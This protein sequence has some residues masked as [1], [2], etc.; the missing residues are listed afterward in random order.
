MLIQVRNRVEVPET[1]RVAKVQSL[2]N[3]GSEKGKEFDLDAD[4]PVDSEGWNIGVVVG[5]SGSGKSSIGRELGAAG[6]ELWHGKPWGPGAI[7]DE[8]G[9]DDFDGATGSLAQVGLGTVPSWLR[10]FGVLSE[11]EKF[12]AEL[13]RVLVERPTRVVIDEF[14]SVVDRQ[15]AQI[16]AMA[17]AKAWKRGEGQAVLLTCH[18]DIL[19][20]V[21]ADW[22]YDTARGEMITEEVGA[23][24]K[25]RMEVRQT[26][27]AYWKSEFE[28]HHYLEAPNMPFGTAF[29]GFVDGAPV[30]HL[31]MTTMW[32]G[33][34]VAAR[35]CRMVVAPEWQ[36]AGIGMRFLNLMAEREWVGEGWAKRPA[37]TYF[38]TAHPALVAALRRDPRWRQVSSKL[39]GGRA[40]RVHDRQ[41]MRYGGH[42]R[43]VA[44][45]V[46]GGAK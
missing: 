42:W 31:G 28:R 34:R 5:P 2:F 8:I 16:G 27:W 23:R 11:G 25:V 29:V 26:G 1:F 33:N 10:P 41:T 32:A 6:F 12:R 13:A 24:P 44:G 46:Y 4:L 7:V 38:H 45:F 37:P 36:G 39:F 15:I 20:W 18:Y 40:A 30:A 19:P 22:V 21:G 3:V 43:A 17:F 9:G 35:A 14:T